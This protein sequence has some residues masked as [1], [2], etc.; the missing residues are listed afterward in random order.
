MLRLFRTMP[1]R[2]RGCFRWLRK[3][4]MSAGKASVVALLGVAILVTSTLAAYFEVLVPTASASNVQTSITVLNTPPVWDTGYFASEVVASATNTPT[5]IGATLSFHA[6]ATDSSN[7][8]YFLII[9]EATS[10]PPT[11]HPL[12]P[13]TCTPTAASK[14][15]QWAISPTTTSGILATS[16]TT[17]V[18]NTYFATERNDWTAWVCDAVAANPSCYSTP[19][20]GEPS[21]AS[22][23]DDASPFVINHPPAFT[24][25]TNDSPQDPGSS[26][27]WTAT[28]TDTDH[29]RGVD[30]IT[31]FVCKANSFSTSTSCGGGTGAWA[32]S[33]PSS[34]DTVATSSP[35]QIP[36]P[37]ATY[38]AYT[39]IMDQNNLAA[40]STQQGASRSFTVNNVTPTVDPSTISLLSS[41]AS[42]TLYLLN[43]AASTS[44]YKI[45]FQVTDNN[46]CRTSTSTNEIVIS[47][48]TVYRSGVGRS[49]CELP[50]D[51]NSNS[52]YP[53]NGGGYTNFVCVQDNTS[54]SGTSDST[55]TWSCTFSL[56]FN[57]DPTDF[58]TQF[59]AQNWLGAVQ[60]V[61][62]NASSSI[63]QES[64]T[65]AELSSFLAFGVATTAIGYG[66]LQPGQSTSPIVQTTDLTEQG[67][68][69][70]NENLYGDTMCTNWT[71][72][73][74]CDTKHPVPS[75]TST[76]P[77]GNQKFATS[78]VAYS[79]AAYIAFPLTASTS[80]T[81]LELRVPKTTATT[82]IQTKNTYWGIAVPASVTL[83][84]SYLGQDT[85]IG[86]KSDPTY[87]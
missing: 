42:T 82:S 39:F 11:P 34:I 14:L 37:D 64:T 73:D 76:I 9:C 79:S 32:T 78:S 38:N 3:A 12:A 24:A 28:A 51:F 80:P 71:T 52:C 20:T 26:I 74:S 41:D 83:S 1:K 35:I 65:G 63:Q 46:S 6:K 72:S 56:W 21:S 25:V 62:N 58:S 10:T 48:T 7:D 53:S 47:T 29:I 85:I 50:G 67:N 57:A 30:P 16:S 69:G 45:T 87:W 5:N 43:P 70:L 18:E 60:V 23:P 59:T 31:L 66:A 22:Y 86:V 81:L 27:T 8:N 75:A 44:N 4:E 54:C 15:Y 77:V 17:T 55:V 2:F 40:T 84:G 61:D 68:I 13:P 33:S 19:T 49:A 36:T